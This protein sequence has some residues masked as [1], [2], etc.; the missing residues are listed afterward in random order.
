[1]KKYVGTVFSN[2]FQAEL[3]HA[4][5]ESMYPTMKHHLPALV[6]LPQV[7]RQREEAAQLR[8][9]VMQDQPGEFGGNC[10]IAV[11]IHTVDG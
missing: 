3:S 1:M 4:C 5:V 2:S 8:V 11:S 10:C 7:A 6:A 9:K